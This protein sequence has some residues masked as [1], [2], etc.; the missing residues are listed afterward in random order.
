MGEEGIEDLKV[1]VSETCAVAVG[2]L[3]RA[4][5]LDP[6]EIDLVEDGPLRDRGSRSPRRRSRPR[7]STARWTTA[8]SAWPWSA[9]WSTTSRRD[10]EGGGNRTP[11]SAG[12]RRASAPAPPPTD[13]RPGG[14]SLT[15]GP[16]AAAA[17]L[18]RRQP[19][20]G[21]PVLGP[22]A[23]IRLRLAG[24]RDGRFP[25]AVPGTA[26]RRGPRSRLPWT[27]QGLGLDP[28]RSN[29]PRAGGVEEV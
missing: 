1:A 21:C 4:G 17:D 9:P 15:P 5:R 26:P 12:A 16:P 29:A 23:M 14:W 3:S 11:S 25:G 18:R 27:V 13:Q 28:G 22:V 7:R 2:D 8:S 19:F 6:I 10:L 24:S 20:P